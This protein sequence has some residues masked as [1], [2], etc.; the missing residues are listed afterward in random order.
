LPEIVARAAGNSLSVNRVIVDGVDEELR[1]NQITRREFIF[2]SAAMSVVG[3]RGFALAK[4]HSGA[5]LL[6]VGT[7]TAATSKGIYAYSFAAATGELRSLGLAA[8]AD[9]PTFLALA[10]NGRTV[11][12]ANELDAY[13]GKSS[14]AVSSYT[15]DRAKARLT[16]VNEVASLGGGTCHVAVDHSGRAAFA[17]NY[18]GG[19]AASF[20]VGA[21]GRLSPAV[22]F[23]QYSG[24]GPDK[25]RQ[26]GPHAH[27][28]TVSP[29]NRFLLVNDLGLD[30][31]HIYRL[32]AATAKLSPN[33]PAVWR[34]NPGAGP[35][36]L[37]FHPNGRIAYCVTEM[38][39]AVVVLRW[40]ARPGVLETV[41]E[42]AM[43]PPEFQG[44][45]GGADIVIDREAR[46]AYAADRFD[47]I[48][49]TFAISPQD[50]RLTV[51]NRTSCGGKV[52]RHLALDPSGRWL[53]VANQVSD[54][55][56]VLARDVQTGQLAA[57]KSFPLSKPQCLV[58]A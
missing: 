58:F 5:R 10:P 17:A 3:R 55:I 30:A 2:G 40:D 52:P 12:V 26:K 25:D 39:S 57:A 29:D 31:I 47:D 33:E 32:D 14:G 11:I 44:T 23:F 15:L 38:A 28:V 22:S 8:A 53:L 54:N 41:Q 16:K 6:L 9:N 56:A 1:L 24:E 18:G 19:S 35:R 42:V 7:Q 51:L 50:G 43:R 20:S 48:I 45:T 37:Q 34:S 36:A 13:E 49:V 21:D 46:F 4:E 27:R